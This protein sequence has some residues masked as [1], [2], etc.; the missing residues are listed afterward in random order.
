LFYGYFSR[1]EPDRG[2]D[3]TAIRILERAI[4]KLSEQRLA[5]SLYGGYTGVAWTVAHLERFL[6]DP[7]GE[8]SNAS[9]D[10]ALEQ[11]L[12]RAVWDGPYDL[13]D[14]LVGFGTYALERLPRPSAEACLRRIIGHLERVSVVTPDGVT[15]WSPPKFLGPIGRRQFPDGCYNL[16]VAHGTPGIIALLT[17]ACVARVSTETSRRL[18]DGAISWLLAQELKSDSIARFPCFVGPGGTSGRSR[19][20]W[21][22]GDL[23]IAATLLSAAR[24]LGNPAWEREALRTA[25]IAAA[26]SQE[27]S[28]VVDAGLCHGAAGVAHVFNRLFQATG[29]PS[30]HDAA[31]RWY[32]RTLELR[33]PGEGVA[34]YV[35]WLPDAHGDLGWRDDRGLLT[36]I[37]GIGLALLAGLSP[38]EPGWDRFLLPGQPADHEARTR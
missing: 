11:E 31:L 10:V 7:A 6:L 12:S 1:F 27:Q 25:R 38:E 30:L 8:D 24:C 22:Y 29:D 28:G 14:G 20:A 19:L 23:G 36:G 16:G 26:R 13:I 18:L 32:R 2:R 35:A 17:A 15:W 5:P 4:D 34:G 37:A 3:R 21:C 9:I 33:R